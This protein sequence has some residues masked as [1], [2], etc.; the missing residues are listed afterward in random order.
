MKKFGLI[1]VFICLGVMVSVAQKFAYVDTQ[2]I[3]D[4][5]P[6]Y[7]EAQNQLDALSIQFQQEIEEKY[8]E[9]DKLYK[10]YQ[11]EAVLLP[12]DMKKRKE[13]EI[14]DKEKDAKNLQKQRFGKDG[15]LFKKRE[16][17][18]KPIQE[19]VYNA[20]QDISTDNNYAIVFDKGGSLTML[21][22]NPK[23]DISDE[24]LDNLGIAFSARKRASTP[25]PASTTP[26][27]TEPTKGQQEKGNNPPPNQMPRSI[28][29]GQQGGNEGIERK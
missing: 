15:D 23:Y 22:S 13:N 28:T 29:P 7:N 19:K 2:Y 26:S 11:A 21:Y 4:N 25:A 18:I 10:D 1:L 16:E 24:V 12:E 3:L 20:I 14:I 8:A 6:E 27:T 9:V 5:L 17:L